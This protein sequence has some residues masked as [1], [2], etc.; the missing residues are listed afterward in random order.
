[1]SEATIDAKRALRMR[2]IAR[3]DQIPAG[4][5]ATDSE[6]ICSRVLERIDA[7]A[8]Q[9]VAGRS[10]TRPARTRPPVVAVFCSFGSEVSL[11]A[12]VRAVAATPAARRPRLVA[13][14][15]LG[16]RHMEFVVVEPRELL[17]RAAMP[18][19]LAHP[20]RAL[21]T[22]MPAG[23]TPVAPADIDLMVMPGVAFDERCG[24]VGYGGGYYDTY[25]ARE[26]FRAATCAVCFDEQVLVGE[27]VPRDPHDRMVDMIL[28]PTRVIRR[29]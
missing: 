22:G 15:S 24:R 13:P 4:T 14:V 16:H 17:D 20:A 21:T 11:D 1:M 6:L 25:L 7:I 8:G 26:G 9:P 28:T 19:F 29:A 5:R 12:L 3:R 2:V 10:A 23:R 27:H 18:D